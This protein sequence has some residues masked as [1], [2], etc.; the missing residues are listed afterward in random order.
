MR[1]R[2]AVATVTIAAVAV[3]GTAAAAPAAPA[4]FGSNGADRASVQPAKQPTAGLTQPVSGVLLDRSGTEA[5]SFSGT[6][7]L[8]RLTEKDGQLFAWGLLEG[9]A[10]T[11]G[12]TSSVSQRV[13]RVPVGLTTGAATQSGGATAATFAGYQLVPTQDVGACQI[14]NLDLGPL[15]LNLLGLVVDLSPISLDVTAV[16]GPGN[17]LGNLLCAVAGLLDPGSPFE[18]LL[19][20]VLDLINQILDSLLGGLSGTAA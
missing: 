10:T 13:N 11:D 15:N 16:P 14:L 3:A 4:T 8:T 6:F 9:Q 18:D 12:T 7:T 1:K 20:D 17:L 19:G 2:R 5:G